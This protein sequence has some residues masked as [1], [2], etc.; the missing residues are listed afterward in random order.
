MGVCQK[1]RGAS[2][3]VFQLAKLVQISVKIYKDISG[4][5]E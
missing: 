5:I 2:L 1:V 3:A 4:P